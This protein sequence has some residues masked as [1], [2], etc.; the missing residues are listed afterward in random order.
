R[1]G[2]LG[3]RSSGD[4]K[5]DGGAAGGA[6]EG[7]L[8]QR[9]GAEGAEK[10]AEEESRRKENS[11]RELRVLRASA[12]RMEGVL[13]ALGQSAF[14]FAGEGFQDLGVAA[15]RRIAGEVGEAADPVREVALEELGAGAADAFGILVAD[16]LA[17]VEPGEE[18]QLGEEMVGG[19]AAIDLE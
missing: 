13:R 18:F 9:G 11:P 5:R 6:V 14:D 10:N 4:G 16:G 19:G 2:D 8:I 15:G 1:G 3:G 12:L 17:V 7:V